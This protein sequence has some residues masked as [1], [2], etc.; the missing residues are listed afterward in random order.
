MHDT[1]ALSL[2]PHSVATENI[3][4]GWNIALIAIGAVA[5]VVGDAI[6]AALGT[7]LAVKTV[8]V[9]GEWH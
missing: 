4:E 3:L 8:Q 6:V 1:H 7:W 9:P 5:F 2:L